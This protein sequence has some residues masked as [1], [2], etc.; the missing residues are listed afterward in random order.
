MTP[1]EPLPMT[2]APAGPL[3]GIARVPGDKSISHRALMLAAMARG[4]SRIDGLSDGTDVAATSAALGAMGV[5]IGRSGGSVLVDGVG[6][7]GL[8]PP[9]GALDMGNS[10]TATRLLMGLVASHPVSAAFTG[11]ASLCRRPMDRVIAPL[12]RLGADILASA[13]GRL[14]LMIRGLCPAVP[15]THRL[16][17]ASAQVKS[18]LLLA[19]LNTPG[20]TRVI[21]PVRTRDH[22]ERLLDR[23]GARIARRGAE[24]ELH[25]EAALRPQHVEVPGDASA[26][27]FLIVAA[28]V[29]PGSHVRIEGVGVNPMRT[30]LFELL[31]AM[32]A[33]L[34]IENPRDLGGEPVADIVAAYSPLRAVDVPPDIIPAMID[35]FPIFF[36]A[37]AFAD[38]VSR[39]TGLAELRVKESDRIA[40]MAAGL[41]AIGVTARDGEDGL[42][43]EGS[44]GRPVA[45]GATIAS[46]L[47]HR[48]AM[49]FAVAGL[50]AAKP[51]TVDDMSPVA[52]S[53][54][55]FASTL[56]ELAR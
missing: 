51:V 44:A 1:A 37:A 15:L 29:V 28:L 3:K 13:G 49:S 5:G 24:I 22:S 38:G 41:R 9:E 23:F 33:D 42:V 48:V 53:F 18:A 19:A 40:A 16:D 30:G 26:A 46:A 21:E 11:D 4:T 20:I 27:A 55:A 6:T 17:I 8:L 43:V 35:E 56:G 39:A 25:G 31:G 10:G 34:R 54:P 2:F 36:I 50:H 12:R 32:G 52:T 14:P 47:D 45:G 7:G